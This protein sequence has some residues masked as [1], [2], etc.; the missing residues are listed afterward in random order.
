MHT[1]DLP[2]EKVEEVE[3][4]HHQQRDDG[5][6]RDV[7]GDVAGPATRHAAA[8]ATRALHTH[9]SRLV[10]PLQDIQHVLLKNKSIT[11][12]LANTYFYR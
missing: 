3:Q 11:L 9:P 4:Q 2:D 6:E 1:F 7:V 10:P 8:H 5:D 12:G